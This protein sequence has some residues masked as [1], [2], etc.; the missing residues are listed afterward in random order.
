MQ[1]V[2]KRLNR[3]S[4]EFAI[5]WCFDHNLTTLPVAGR[6]V[7]VEYEF[8]AEFEKPLIEVLKGKHGDRWKEYYAA[9]DSEDITRLFSIDEKSRPSQAVECEFDINKFYDKI[10]YE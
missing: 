6:T 4:V 7:V 9:Y 5:R 10:H 2:A 8:R 3:K 1:E